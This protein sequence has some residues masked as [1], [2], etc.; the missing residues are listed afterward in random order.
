MEDRK[1]ML[2]NVKK[3][4]FAETAEELERAHSHLLRT[5]VCCKYEYF[6]T[7]MWCT[8]Y[9]QGLPVR[10]SQSGAPSQ[11]LPVR[12]S[13]SAAPSQG[14]PVRGSQSAAPSQRLPVRGSQS[15]APSQGLP[16]RGNHTQNYVEAQFRIVKD[17]L[18]NQ[19]RSYNAVDWRSG[20]PLSR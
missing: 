7:E 18:L 17:E 9:S 6:I 4:S 10:G 14:L 1:E 16:V 8:L 11:R 2:E 19:V 15:A 12:G 3:I 13:Q 20:R 5:S